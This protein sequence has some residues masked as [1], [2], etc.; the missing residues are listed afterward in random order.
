MHRYYLELAGELVVEFG[1]QFAVD[2]HREM[3]VERFLVG[4]GRRVEARGLF[5]DR[6]FFLE[7]RGDVISGAVNQGGVCLDLDLNV[8]DRL[9]GR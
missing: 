2:V 3:N 1:Q 7:V 5:G 6:C 4:V 9:P 8:V